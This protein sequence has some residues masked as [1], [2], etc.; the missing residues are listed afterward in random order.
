MVRVVGIDPG[1][2]SID[3]CGLCN[4]KVCFEKSIDTVEASRNP[5]K[6]IKALEEFGEFDVVVAPSGYGVEVKWFNDIPRELFSDWY[7]TF[8]LL[9]T[10]DEIGSAVSKGIEGALIYDAMVKLA[11][12][13]R[14]KEIPALLIPG[15]INLSTIPLHRKINKV[16]MG[17]ADK[18]AVAV[19]GIHEVAD[20][21]D[22][23]YSSV[24]Y[25]HVEMGYGYNAVIA[26]S[27]GR[28]VDGVGGSLTPGPAYLTAGSLDLEVAQAIGS[29]SKADVFTTGC[30]TYVNL[31]L[32]NWLRNPYIDRKSEICFEAMIESVIKA[33]N[34]VIPSVEK[35]SLILL[36]GRVSKYSSVRE[37]LQDKLKNYP[38]LDIMRGLKNAVSVKET[39]QGYAVVGDGLLNGVFG[40]LIDHVMIRDAEGSSLDYILIPKFFQTLLGRMFVKLRGYFRKPAFNLLWWGYY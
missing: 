18:L 38:S 5:E 16:D 34:M 12:F 33:I 20:K 28:I 36:S 11:S 10:R 14:N 3:I 7:L 9:T 19:L 25:I 17:T 39:A 27:G 35:P 32:D 4:G 15:V 29:F 8:I 1:S 30:L 21:E 26:V 6:L 40:E 13:L 2:R 23:D 31:D 24:N 37:V 22:T